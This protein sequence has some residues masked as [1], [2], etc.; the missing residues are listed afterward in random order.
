M[1]RICDVIAVSSISDV[2]GF[3]PVLTTEEPC[4]PP[5]LMSRGLRIEDVGIGYGLDRIPELV[6]D[7]D[8]TDYVVSSKTLFSAFLLTPKVIET[9]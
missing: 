6:P 3:S 9:A 4:G 8:R 7:P 1:R 5:E 2:I